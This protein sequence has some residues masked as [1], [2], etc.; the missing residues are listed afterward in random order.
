MK[1]GA[2]RAGPFPFLLL[3][4]LSLGFLFPPGVSYGQ[5]GPKE[6]EERL[7]LAQKLLD[8]GEQAAAIHILEELQGEEPLSSISPQVGFL[9]GVLYMREKRWEEAK[10]YLERSALSYPGLLDYSLFYLAEADLGQG[11]NASAIEAL[12]KLL[13]LPQESR[14]KKRARLQLAEAYWTG[15][16]LA[17]AKRIYRNILKDH[18]GPSYSLRAQLGLAKIAIE[19]GRQQEAASLFLQIELQGP[20]SPEARLAR[21]F[22]RKLT[23]PPH[24]NWGQRFQ[25]GQALYSA[26]AYQ[27]AAEEFKSLMADPSAAQKDRDRAALS[28]GRASFRA[29]DYRGVVGVLSSLAERGEG[30]EAAECLYWLGRSHIRLGERE[31]GRFQLL[32]LTCQFPRSPWADDSW[33]RLG[34]DEEAEG[35][36]F[37]A[38]DSYG[39]LIVFY[40]KSELKED[41]L[42]HRAWV[43]YRQGEPGLAL[44]D[45]QGLA[46]SHPDSPQTSQWLYWTG[47]I[48]ERV[49]GPAA[50]ARHYRQ[51]LSR[52]N[53]DYYF[54][55]ASVR[56]AALEAF[57]P[58][59]VPNGVQIERPDLDPSSSPPAVKRKAPPILLD[60]A[61]T[62]ISLGLV[63]EGLAE[64]GEAI[65]RAPQDRDLTEEACALSLSLGRPNRTLSWARQHQ[66]ASRAKGRDADVGPLLPYLYPLGY[67]E[68]VQTAGGDLGMDPFM[69]LAVIREESS[70][71]PRC[72]SGAGAR[73][74]MQLM[75]GTA[76]QVAKEVG[77]PFDGDEEDLFQPDLNIRLGARYLRDLLEEFPGNLD[78]AVASYN[79]GP[80]PVR[81]WLSKFSDYDPE[82][83]IESIPYAET[84]AY[85]KRVL[86]SYE[87]YKLLY[88]GKT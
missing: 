76:S 13:A 64:Y 87:V 67:P 73:G 47:R 20:S 44:M 63:E 79:A 38:Q 78:L 27:R 4:I 24:L 55:R 1:E 83:F 8:N 37:Q 88:Q 21:T 53:F 68:I 7:H 31:K 45:L 33:Y 51:I 9:L 2:R 56:L 62:L 52:P 77:E 28:A 34:L 58:E 66:S 16:D 81:R 72:V 85:V 25:R 74:L 17:A 50:A 49:D 69:I 46:S 42:W 70:F 60:K 61:R 15:H 41:A 32:R 80:R 23:P 75:T 6:Q 22:W 10:A 54:F 82:E 3:I 5:C 65:Q 39:R 48:L 71:S 18:P 11:Q 59:A 43:C 30:Q 57:L 86:R 36:F 14:L 40:P 35:D 26:E 29:R 84:R 12:K 19:E